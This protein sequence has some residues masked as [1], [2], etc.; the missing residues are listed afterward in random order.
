M[1]EF[2]LTPEDLIL[3][4]GVR[5]QTTEV[6]KGV[7][8]IITLLLVA[9]IARGHVLLEGNPGLGK[10]A[11]VRA[12]SS[13]LGFP[14]DDV[15]RIQFTPDLMPSDIT[16]T[17]LPVES[18]VLEFKPGPIFCKLLLA[19]EINRATPKTQAA[20]LEAMAEFQVTVLGKRY[21]LAEP[22]TVRDDNKLTVQSPFMVMATQN[23]VEQ[24]GTYDLPEAQLDRFMFKIRMPFP[25]RDTLGAIVRKETGVATNGM[26]ER[27]DS[28]DVTLAN[29]HRVARELRK[30]KPVEEVEAHIMNIVIASTGMF[31]QLHD[32][33]K[34][35]LDKLD[36]F[37]TE[38]IDY[39]LGPRAAISL[40][41]ACLGWS[42]LE[43]VR[44]EDIGQLEAKTVESLA[45]VAVPTLRHRIRFRR[46]YVGSELETIGQAEWHDGCLRQFLSL[47]APEMNGY[48]RD[49]D[50]ASEEAANS[51]RF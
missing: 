9:L 17:Q 11:L 24:E 1:R 41:H 47:S 48:A 50:A 12:L 22:R 4:R 26:Q 38:Y 29:L 36:Q 44:P 35:R 45:K 27:T 32:I 3:L 16:G 40:T 49:F 28:V 13:A 19:D 21:P 7:D 37:C 15:G 25:E 2:S 39:P 43:E 23:P 31:K 20:M 51:A 33:P 34:D 30:S 6:M 42:V 10:T 8:G 14:P 5:K 46:P 18:G